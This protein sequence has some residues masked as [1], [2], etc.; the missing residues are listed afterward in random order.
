[1][2]L[3]KS[4]RPLFWSLVQK[5]FSEVSC[6]KAFWESLRIGASLRMTASSSGQQRQLGQIPT[7]VSMSAGTSNELEVYE[8]P[9]LV[10]STLADGIEIFS[11]GVVKKTM[12]PGIGRIRCARSSTFCFPKRPLAASQLVACTHYDD[13]T[14]PKL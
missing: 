3:V 11:E 12:N 9:A 14:R 13:D 6:R 2:A 8:C 5:A 1:V 4:A 10:N 7:G